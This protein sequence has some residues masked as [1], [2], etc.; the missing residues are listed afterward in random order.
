MSY[1]S[2]IISPAHPRRHGGEVAVDMTGC[3]RLHEAVL[4]C[5]ALVAS[6]MAG[7]LEPETLNSRHHIQ[8]GSR[9]TSTMDMIIEYEFIVMFE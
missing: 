6:E 7:L 8:L 1:Y 3:I 5:P 4:S 9:C 2:A